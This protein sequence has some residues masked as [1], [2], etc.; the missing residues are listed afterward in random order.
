MYL[1][2]LLVTLRR[3]CLAGKTLHILVWKV[4]S[5]VMQARASQLAQGVRQTD[6]HFYPSHRRLFFPGIWIT[7]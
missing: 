7:K 6:L 3:A 2:D 5:H 4:K 1:I